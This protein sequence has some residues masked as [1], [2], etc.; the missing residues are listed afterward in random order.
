MHKLQ[1]SKQGKLLICQIDELISLDISAKPSVFQQ[2]QTSKRHESEFPEKSG[3]PANML[4]NVTDRLCKC[5]VTTHPQSVG[6]YHVLIEIL[7]VSK[8]ALEQLFAESV[9]FFRQCHVLGAFGRLCHLALAEIFS[10]DPFHIFVGC[11]IDGC[12]RPLFRCLEKGF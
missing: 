12:T 7:C 6:S 2:D 5:G 9:E 1:F 10:A 11:K 8:S 3:S 4:Y